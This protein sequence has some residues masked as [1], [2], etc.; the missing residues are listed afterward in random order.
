LQVMRGRYADVE[1]RPAQREY[2]PTALRGM[3]DAA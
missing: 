1:L 3:L 2:Q